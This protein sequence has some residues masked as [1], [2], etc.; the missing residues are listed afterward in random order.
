MAAV[1][2]GD[3][4]YATLWPCH[5]ER[6]NVSNVNYQAGRT[7]ANTAI[8]KLSPTGSICVYTFADTDLIVDIN[9]HLTP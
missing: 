2:P 4:G 7:T 6:P 8:T 5:D 3:H 1:N 9:A